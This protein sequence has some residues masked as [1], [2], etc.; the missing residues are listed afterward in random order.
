MVGVETIRELHTLT[1]ISAEGIWLH[2]QYTRTQYMSAEGIWLHCQYTRTQYMSAEGIWLHC[3][4]TR[5]QYMVIHSDNDTVKIL[6][7]QYYVP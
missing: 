4:Y 2:C 1:V 6:S 3:Q 5:T 7:L